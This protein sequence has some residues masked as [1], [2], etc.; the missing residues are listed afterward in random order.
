MAEA[1]GGAGHV[2]VTAQVE[3]GFHCGSLNCSTGLI[4]DRLDRADGRQ[5]LICG[6]FRRVAQPR[7]GRSE[8][9]ENAAA[10][11]QSEVAS[12]KAYD[13]VAIFEFRQADE[14]ARQ[15]FADEGERA[16]P[17]DFAT[18][19]HPPDL[20]VGVIPGVFDAFRQQARRGRIEV[21][22]RLLPERLVRTLLIIMSSELVEAR[23]LLRGVGAGGCEV[24][25]FN[26]RCMRSCRP[27]SCG[28]AGRMK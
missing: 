6:V 17:F 3:S 7:A 15:R 1:F 23:L 5:V 18:G 20:V 26:V 12:A 27:L 14:L 8:T 22:R 4:L 19:P 28:E 24:C 13:V 16:P 25:F 9:A 10:I 21:G 2:L 11:D